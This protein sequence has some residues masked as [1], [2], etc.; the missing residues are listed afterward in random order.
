MA[1]TPEQKAAR[2]MTNAISDFRFNSAEFASLM[3]RDR[4][5]NQRFADLLK[6]YVTLAAIH[7]KYGDWESEQEHRLLRLMSK[8]EQ[9]I[10][11]D[12]DQA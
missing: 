5:I 12:A 1:L 11:E 3:I 7:Y 2:N 9:V 10:L 8:I 4:N 6:S